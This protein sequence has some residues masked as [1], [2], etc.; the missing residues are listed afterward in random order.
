M[1]RMLIAVGAYVAQDLRDAEGMMRP[2]LRRVAIRLALS[3]REPARRLGDA[4]LHLDPPAVGADPSRR[5]VI[6]VS[7]PPM[8]IAAA[9]A[10]APVVI[11]DDGPPP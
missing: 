10:A 11:G 2:V 9:R 8:T 1:T 7:A 4:C 6:A 5:D 3:S